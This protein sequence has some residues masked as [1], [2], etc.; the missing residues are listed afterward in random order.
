[1]KYVGLTD[2]PVRRRTEHGNPVDWVYQ[3]LESELHARMWERMMLSQ[4]GHM[5]GTGGAGRRYGYVYTIT[6]ST[7]Q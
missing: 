3:P 5:G 2:D 7:V 6:P 4:P 1:M